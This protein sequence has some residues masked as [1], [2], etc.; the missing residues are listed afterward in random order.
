MWV[1]KEEERERQLSV[2]ERSSRM[3]ENASG[4]L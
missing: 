2:A 1:K 4:I 3:L